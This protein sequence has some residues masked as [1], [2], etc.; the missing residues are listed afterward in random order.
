MVSAQATRNGFLRAAAPAPPGGGRPQHP[1]RQP[2]LGDAAAL[3]H[4]P[5]HRRGHRAG[6]RLRRRRLHDGSADAA[7]GRLHGRRKRTSGCRRNGASDRDKRAPASARPRTKLSE[8]AFGRLF[9]S[10]SL[11]NELYLR[12]PEMRQL[13]T[14]MALPREVVATAFADACSA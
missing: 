3:G 6:S 8:I 10:P 14:F 7:D 13:A 12:V 9:L 5:R 4:H 2:H 1:H 11:S